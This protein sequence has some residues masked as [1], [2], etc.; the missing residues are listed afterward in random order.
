MS[1][2]H[3]VLVTPLLLLLFGLLHRVHTVMQLCEAIAVMLFLPVVL[4]PV[5]RP[6]EHLTA[7]I[8]TARWLC[9]LPCLELLM[10]RLVFKRGCTHALHGSRFMGD[11]RCP[12][13]MD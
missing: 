1:N 2:A 3:S 9:H 12:H 6:I 11:F 5:Q 4:D 7:V 13:R 8:H 10:E